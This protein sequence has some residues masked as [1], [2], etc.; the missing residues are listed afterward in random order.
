MFKIS[1]HQKS[2]DHNNHDGLAYLLAKNF[3]GVT[4]FEDVLTVAPFMG[5]GEREEVFKQSS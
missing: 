4:Y 5:A 1:Y 3:E 2:C